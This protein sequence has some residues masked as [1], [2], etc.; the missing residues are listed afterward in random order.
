MAAAQV[1]HGGRPQRGQRVGEPEHVREFLGIALLAPHLVI[2]VLGPAPAVDARGLDVAERIGRDPDVV[3]GRRD[4]ERGDTL[5]RLG[6]ADLGAR[7][8]A[9]AETSAPPLAVDPRTVRVTA[10]QPRNRSGQ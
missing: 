4:A 7:G 2:S 10:D 5:H 3:P 1:P 6:I 9:I 8:I